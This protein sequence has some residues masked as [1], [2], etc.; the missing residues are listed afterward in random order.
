LLHCQM[1]IS[2]HMGSERCQFI[3]DDV[4]VAGH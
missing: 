3:E 1:A 4:P 2:D